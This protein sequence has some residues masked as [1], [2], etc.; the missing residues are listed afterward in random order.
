M[1]FCIYLITLLSLIALI[2]SACTS[3]QVDVSAPGAAEACGTAI[4][5]CTTYDSTSTASAPKCATCADGYL[6]L[7]DKETCLLGCKTEGTGG[8]AGK[9]TACNTG[10]LLLADEVTCL[11]GC[12]TEGTGSDA[13]KCTACNDGY[14]L[15]SG[16]CTASSG[17]NSPTGGD[18]N[19][20]S[21]SLHGS[22]LIILLTILF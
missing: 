16:T 21:F 10:Y 4:P 13:G 6:L 8:D 5:D 19:N 9:C 17:S 12:K 2:Y 7:A 22:L 18:N 11:L 14:T 3:P 20:N 1:K 15:S